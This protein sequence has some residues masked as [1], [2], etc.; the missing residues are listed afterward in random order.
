LTK[1]LLDDGGLF[2]EPQT[3]GGRLR[4]QALQH[5]FLFVQLGLLG[6]VLVGKHLLA[7]NAL[8]L[9]CRELFLLGGDRR[10]QSRTLRGRG[11]FGFGALAVEGGECVLRFFT[12]TVQ[13]VAELVDR[14]LRAQTLDLQLGQPRTCALFFVGTRRRQRGDRGLERRAF[15]GQ[16]VQSLLL[17]DALLPFGF[18]ELRE[19]VLAGFDLVTQGGKA[20][21]FARQL[22]GLRVLRCCQRVVGRGLVALQ[23]LNTLLLVSEACCVLGVQLLNSLLSGK[24]LGVQLCQPR[25]FG[26][27][28]RGSSVEGRRQ[29]ELQRFAFGLQRLQVGFF[30]AT[31]GFALCG[32][33]GLFAFDDDAASGD[34]VEGG[35][36]IGEAL[37]TRCISSVEV[38]LHLLLPLGDGIEFRLVFLHPLL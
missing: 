9:Q 7:L 12:T 5:R 24:A 31:T 37:H 13:L 4:R 16:R 35:G 23:L 18:V 32:G 36:F 2:G 25:F 10:S 29:L 19:V 6:G 30:V 17:S 22:M 27:C 14:F 28:S 15:C 20:C 1:R 11:D 21:L 3:L 33:R 34:V 26:V 8:L 38:A